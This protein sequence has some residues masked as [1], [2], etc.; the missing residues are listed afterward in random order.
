MLTIPVL[1]A[2]RMIAIAMV[3]MQKMAMALLYFMIEKVRGNVDDRQAAKPVGLS[4]VP[5]TVKCEMEFMIW[6]NCKIPYVDSKTE[7]EIR[8]K[9]IV[10]SDILFS[11]KNISNK[12]KESNG[13]HYFVTHG[14]VFDKVTTEMKWLAKLGDVGYT[15]L[16]WMNGMYNKF[17]AKHGKPYFSLS[18]A[19]KQ[20]VKSAVSYIS[21]FET[22]LVD[23]ARKRECDGVICGHIH[24]PEN[25]VIDGVHYLNSGDWVE[26]L[27]A[28]TEDE[29]GVWEV[30]NYSELINQ[31]NKTAKLTLL[32]VAS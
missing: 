19:I 28:L 25:R 6:K 5:E 4:N 24:H 30:V 22:V 17:R 9:L 2:E 26:T 32:S 12:I 15:L 20:K 16:L 11:L 31:L 23:F 18:Q 29:N 13:R 27:S 1:E 14:D 10:C 3:N 8:H 7:K 21:D